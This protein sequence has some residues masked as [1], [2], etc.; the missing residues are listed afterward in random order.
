[1]PWRYYLKDETLI[2]E[3]NF[4]AISSGLLGGWRRVDYL[5][6]HTVN[7]FDLDNPVEYLEKVA[8]KHGLKNYFGLLTSVPMDKLAIK[9]VDDVTVFV[10]AGVKNPNERIGTINT[11]IV[12]DAEM[13]GGAMVNAVITATEAKAKALIE[14]GYDFTGTNTDA[15]IVA[16]CGG[17]YYEYA[18]PMSELGQKIWL[19]VSGAV[20]ESLLKWD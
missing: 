9:R 8:N 14:L 4:E 5:F 6:N 1:M 11:I 18:G 7:D 15:V 19:A 17:K 13:S 2:V 10:T 16:M 20:K 12:V 3:G